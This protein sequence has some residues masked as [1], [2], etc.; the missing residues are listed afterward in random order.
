VRAARVAVGMLFFVNALALT[1]VLPRLPQI[2]ADLGLTNTALGLALAAAPVGSLVAVPM[3]GRLIARFGSAAVAAVA[4]TALGL[5]LPLLAL[6]P[7]GIALAATY[8]ALGAADGV[9]DAAMNAHGLRVQ[10]QYGRSL[11]NGMHGLWSVGAAAGA[12]TG[13]AAAAFGVPLGLHLGVVGLLTLGGAA[14]AAVGR[15]PGPDPAD[16]TAHSAGGPM[17]GRSE[18]V[19]AGQRARGVRTAMRAL[20]W[21]GVLSVLAGIGEDVAGTWSTVY[22]ADGRGAAPGIAGLGYTCFAAAMV[23][24]RFAADRVTDRLGVVAVARA[25]GLLAMLGYAL[26]LVSPT[27]G[28]AVA[29]FAVIG[30]GVAPAFPALFHAAGH[31]PGVRSGD[32]VTVVSWVARMGFLVTPPLVGLVADTAGIAAGLVLGGAAVGTYGMLAGR[33]RPGARR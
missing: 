14:A 12:A 24:S 19:G 15:L 22:L 29:G 13:T 2:K 5:G 33:L 23:L 7:S 32:G 17:A 30:L 10:Q 6:A 11:I 28:L 8:L 21:V 4:G 3:T 1:T 20:L 26:V 31:W 18:G 16:L 9:M 27:V 25:G